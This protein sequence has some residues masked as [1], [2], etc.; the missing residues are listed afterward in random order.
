M[1]ERSEKR[2]EL[3][4]DRMAGR[5]IS[6][7]ALKDFKIE[8][9]ERFLYEYEVIEKDLKK[10]VNLKEKLGL[11]VFKRLDRM[12]KAGSN[13]AIIDAIRSKVRAEKVRHLAGAEKLIERH[14]FFQRDV[15]EEEAVEYLFQDIEEIL[16]VFPEDAERKGKNIAK[17]IFK[18]L[19]KYIWVQEED[20]TLKPSLKD[21]DRT[22]LKEYILD[23]IPP[24]HIR[25]KV[26]A[27]DFGDNTMTKVKKEPMKKKMFQIR[28]VE[29]KRIEKNTGSNLNK[30][31][32]CS[33]DWEYGHTEGF[34]YRKKAG[35]AARPHPG[36]DELKKRLDEYLRRKKQGTIPVKAAKRSPLEEEAERILGAKMVKLAEDVVYD[37]SEEERIRLN[38]VKSDYSDLFKISSIKSRAGV[39]VE[40]NGKKYDAL[41]DL[42]A[43]KSAINYRLRSQCDEVMALEKCVRV[44]AAGGAIYPVWEIGRMKE[45]KVFSSRNQNASL[46]FKDVEVLILQIEEWDDFIIGNEILCRYAL[47]PLSALEAAIQF[48]KD[49]PEDCL[50]KWLL[51]TLDVEDHNLM[52]VKKVSA[53]EK[54]EWPKNE[55]KVPPL[56]F[57]EEFPAQED[58]MDMEE[59]D[60]GLGADKIY[61]PEEEQRMKLKIEGKVK[62]ISE[63]CFHDS[64]TWKEKFVSLFVSYFEAFGDSESPTKLSGITPIR[65]DLIAG[66]VVG[67]QKQIPLGQEQE[68][69][70]HT[71]IQQMIKSGIIYVN[72]NPTTAMSVLVVPKKGPKRFRLVVDFRPLNDVTQKVNNTLPRIELQLDRVR[73]NKWFAGFDLLS[74]FDYLACEPQAGEYFT[75]T[76][77]WGVAYSFYGAPQGWCNT[78]SLFSMRQIEEVLMQIDLWPDKALQWIDDTI[79]MGQNMSELYSNMEKF[80]KQIKKKNLRLNLDMCELVSHTL[81]FCGREFTKEGWKFNDEYAA[82][83][84]KRVKPIYLHELAQM[85]YTANY[86]SPTIPGFSRIKNIILGSHKISGKLKNLERK[87]ILI[88]WSPEMEA[89]Y[90]EMI[91]AIE[92][93]MKCTIGFYNPEEDVYIFC[94][95]CDRFYSLFISQSSEVVDVSN[96]FASNF[97]VIAMN[98]G[99]FTGSS[100]KW[101]ISC[102]ELYPVMI[103]IKKYPFYLRYNARE[104]ILF[105]DHN[106]LVRILNPKE[107]KLKAHAS[108]LSRWAMEFMEVNIVAH[109]LCGYKNIPAD[110]LSRWLNP[111]YREEVEEVIL[112]RAI[113]QEEERE[114]E[115][116]FWRMLDDLHVSPRHPGSYNLIDNGWQVIDEKFIFDLQKRDM[117]ELTE[118]YKEEDKL[119]ITKSLLPTIIF[120]THILF[121]HGSKKKE[122]KFI[123]D[124]YI[125]SKKVNQVFNEALTRFHKQCMHCQ[126]PSLIVRRPLNITSWGSRAGEVL[127]SDF[128]YVN[129]K[130]WILT[131][132][133]SFTRT[134]ILRYCAKATTDKVVSILWDWHSHFQLLP[135]FVLVTDRGSHFTSKVIEDYLRQSGCAHNF[136]ATYVSPT[137]GAVEVQNKNILKHLRSIVSVFGLGDSDWPDI[138]PMIQSFLN[139]NPLTCRGTNLSPL[140]L[141]IGAGEGKA[142]LGSV[143]KDME[144]RDYE[145]LFKAAI[146]LRGK[147]ERLQEKA[148]RCGLEHRAK[149]NMRKNNRG[150][151]RPI[152]FSVGEYIWLSEKEV[153]SGKKNKVRPRWCGPYQVVECL[154]EHIY[155]VKDMDGKEKVRHSV[156]M[157][158]FAPVSFLPNAATT[159]VFRMDKGNLEVDEFVDLCIKDEGVFYFNV[160]WRG[161]GSEHNTEEPAL[162]M[163]ED[164]PHMVMDFCDNNQSREVSQLLDFLITVYPE[165]EYLKV[166]GRMQNLYAV[167]VEEKTSFC[168]KLVYGKIFIDEQGA[169][170]RPN[171]STFEVQALRIAVLSCGFGNFEKIQAYVPGKSKQNIYTKLQRMVGRQSLKV[172]HGLHLDVMKL[173]DDNLKY[174]GVDYFVQ[175]KQLSDKVVEKKKWFFKWRYLKESEENK[176]KFENKFIEVHDLTSADGVKILLTRVDVYEGEKWCGFPRYNG[177]ITD[178]KIYL[179]DLWGKLKCREKDIQLKLDD[180]KIHVNNAE[181]L[182]NVVFGCQVNETA[183]NNLLEI[184]CKELNFVANIW[185]IPKNVNFVSGDVRNFLM[186]CCEEYEVLVIDPPWN[187]FSSNPTRGPAVTYKT[188]KDVDIINLPLRNVV[189][190]GLVFCWVVRGKEKIV[191]RMF[192]ENGIRYLGRLLWIK[193]NGRDRILSTL[194]NITMKCTEE[195]FIGVKGILPTKLKNKTIGK[196][197]LYGQRAGN[198]R[199]PV[200]LYEL[201]EDNFEVP[202]KYLELFGRKNNLRLGWTTVGDEL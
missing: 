32:L 124:N 13:E 134:T 117:K 51:R 198:A 119:F 73:G 110:C 36:D 178:F 60:I 112:Q 141:M 80:L 100:L 142:A 114:S 118:L 102:K 93:S 202:G 197:I 182:E 57:G 166:D 88:E 149:V 162:T 111:R 87:K 16:S 108:R 106:N 50:A 129:S 18:K 90:D 169:T 147:I 58:F 122:I 10:F 8:N 43:F 46:V 196:E 193:T 137:A 26:K 115:L 167:S 184:C 15:I 56:Y 6:I 116:D 29:A 79:I 163:F 96:P 74:G 71:R 19:P 183:V 187:V 127:L 199:K 75:F 160:K 45:V 35:E 44:Q 151:L 192:E 200:E 164:L 17:A 194:G 4:A 76:T 69:F 132:V 48:R 140:Q 174:K 7:H 92:A 171:W 152:Y 52:E 34:C 31:L 181:E 78:P 61:T 2:L 53:V 103:A 39:L 176:K 70:L 28:K 98:S 37:G 120:H 11:S 133:D 126:K 185:K 9:L 66:T 109:H 84:L 173:K 159:L 85:I 33:H 72:K 24:L 40:V 153:N 1:N 125:L 101:H 131:L 81:T 150:K 121:N 128:L 95:A 67:M 180:L 105:T 91:A 123:K 63:V 5:T 22:E 55:L 12:G 148:D 135:N 191:E 157:I 99:A 146:D 41:L 82:G 139:Q 138:L 49:K 97:R 186:E 154:S 54:E 68:D 77:P 188:M 144:K 143:Y 190:N 172:Y 62:D 165:S 3:I 25:E 27:I 155:K 195:C 175:R 177:T 168:E 65:C 179:K 30:P 83:L 89:A 189:K 107:I 21:G 94:D 38:T 136:T 59:I 113:F 42:G 86:I 201:I 104:K 14:V 64:V 23:C 145:K 156:L 20:L 47:D 130:G 158:P 161:F 170:N